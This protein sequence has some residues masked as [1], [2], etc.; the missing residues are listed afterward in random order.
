MRTTVKKVGNSASIRIPSAVLKAAQLKFDEPVDAREEGGMIVIE[1]LRRLKYSLSALVKA[2]TP[3][4]L[5]EA[6]DLGGPVGNEIW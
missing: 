5:H 6:V 1:R 4:N 3:H 2:I